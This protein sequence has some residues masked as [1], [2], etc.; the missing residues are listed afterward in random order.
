M[1]FLLSLAALTGLTVGNADAL[2]RVR[3]GNRGQVVAVNTPGVRVAVGNGFGVAGRFG[4]PRL[5]FAVNTNRFGFGFGGGHG[6]GF[7]NHGHVGR[8]VN[9][10]FSNYRYNYAAP[11]AF[12]TYY[13][14][15]VSVGVSVVPQVPAYTPLAFS[16]QQ[17]AAPCA[18]GAFP[19][20]AGACG[21]ATGFG[22]YGGG[23]GGGCGAAAGFSTGVPAYGYSTPL[24][25]GAGGYGYGRGFGGFRVGG[26]GY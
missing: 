26:H 21:Q 19:T 24:L 3:V 25:F 23:F 1:K 15:P 18:T 20:Y 7:G 4:G 13:Q 11:V 22:G 2:V 5:G 16:Q 10:G 8:H 9:F 17:F 6:F 14:V 12:P